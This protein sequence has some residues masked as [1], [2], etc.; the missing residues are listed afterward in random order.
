MRTIFSLIFALII[1][2]II[3]NGLIFTLVL[4]VKKT[5]PLAFFPPYPYDKHLALIESAATIPHID[6]SSLGK[7]IEGRDMNPDGT[8]RRT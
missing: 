8:Y 5:I 4:K 2:L 3:S 7:T 6:I 1:N